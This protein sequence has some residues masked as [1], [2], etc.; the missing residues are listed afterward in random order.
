MLAQDAGQILRDVER[1]IPKM[2]PPTPAVPSLAPTIPNE[3]FLKDGETVRVTGFRI[4]SNLIPEKE[5]Q[6]ELA[7]YVG[8]DC[9]LG[10]LKEAAARISRY[11]AQRDLLARAVLPRQSLEGGLV[12][13]QVLEARMGKVKIDLSSDSRLTP[14]RAS[15]FIHAQNAEGAPLSPAAVAIGVSN[16]GNI[17]GMQAMGILDAGEAEG[18]TDVILKL[19]EPP[20]VAG[21]VVIDNNSAREIGRVRGLGMVTLA[22]ASGS[23]EQATVVGQAT[24]S[25]RYGQVSTGLPVMDGEFWL[26][27]MGSALTYDIPRSINVTQPAGT[28]QTVAA[29]ARWLG[30][31]GSGEPISLSVGFEHKWTRDKV[32]GLATARNRLAGIT[33]SARR[34]MRDQWQGGGLFVLDAAVKVGNVD[35]S[36]NQTNKV[37]DKATADTQG[38]YGKFTFSVARRQALWD[39]GDGLV[40]LSGQLATKNLNSAEQFSLGGLS[41]TRGYPVNAG[42]GDQGAMLSLE[43]GHRLHEDVRVAA[44]W[45]GGLIEQHKDRWTGW[46]GLGSPHNSY[47]QQDVGTSVQWSVLKGVQVNGTLA[48]RVGP[49]DGRGIDLRAANERRAELR[50]WM[51]L[52]LAI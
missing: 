37:L 51:Q 12:T 19:R 16:L 27:G 10:D 6:Q 23:G 50:A 2:E 39:G 46:Q 35:L 22:N 34:T 1:N 32:G 7:D 3:E 24:K 42:S 25:S 40:A 28:A 15:A 36:G 52:V 29:N 45:D 17:P 21:T 47:F 11:Y 43:L 48:K 49:D 20:L 44:F 30:L 33:F 18:S 13:I 4:L 31:R 5:L 41:G 14:D 9:A 8:R 26:E 38:K